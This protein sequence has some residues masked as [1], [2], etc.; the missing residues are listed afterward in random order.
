MEP[1]GTCWNEVLK[2]HGSAWTTLS[3]A[4]SVE[5][6]DEQGLPCKDEAG[7]APCHR[8]VPVSGLSILELSACAVLLCTDGAFHH[9]YIEVTGEGA[10]LL[11]RPYYSLPCPVEGRD[12]S[13][14]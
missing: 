6:A 13:S 7:E 10:V 8:P 5:T 14:L 12:F 2:P 11:S 9:S 1:C 3:K 4:S